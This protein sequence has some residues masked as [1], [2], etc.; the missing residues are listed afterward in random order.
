MADNAIVSAEKDTEAS[1]ATQ[2][3]VSHVFHDPHIQLHNRSS[4]HF[5]SQRFI[6]NTRSFI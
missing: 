3:Q 2:E 4:V 5:H 6:G 1:Q